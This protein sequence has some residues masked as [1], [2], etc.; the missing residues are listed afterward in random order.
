VLVIFRNDDEIPIMLDINGGSWAI[1][2]LELS[3][4]TP[5]EHANAVASAA[6]A[7]LKSGKNQTPGKT[8]LSLM[9]CAIIWDDVELWNNA[10]PFS[11]LSPLESVGE[12]IDEALEAFDLESIQTG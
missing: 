5:T 4:D 9:D 7:E 8:A 10:L 11:P 6:L 1:E 2:E 3:T 12:A